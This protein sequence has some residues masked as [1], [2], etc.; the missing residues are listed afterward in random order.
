MNKANQS[1]DRQGVNRFRSLTLAAQIGILA[2]TMAKPMADGV[3]ME[4]IP[5]I[6]DEV[7]GM[8]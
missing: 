6:L 8:R 2:E 7:V 5:T 4:S 1:H 3:D